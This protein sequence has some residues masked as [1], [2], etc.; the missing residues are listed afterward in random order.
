MPSPGRTTV[1]LFRPESIFFEM[2]F[3]FLPFFQALDVGKMAQ[4]DKGG[5]KESED[6]GHIGQVDVAA[7]PEIDAAVE[8]FRQDGQIQHHGDKKEQKG[9]GDGDDRREGDLAEEEEKDEE[10]GTGKDEAQ[11]RDEDDVPGEAGD[12]FP[13]AEAGIERE[14]VTEA[15]A[16]RRQG[17]EKLDQMLIRGKKVRT[18]IIEQQ[19]DGKARKKALEDIEDDRQDARLLADDA[20]DIGSAGVV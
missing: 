8:S 12:A 11:G 5:Q 13:A 15:D 18:D 17:D 1:F 2:R 19:K 4:D 16:C 14:S 3:R 7:R 10:K 6:D 9:R 20:P